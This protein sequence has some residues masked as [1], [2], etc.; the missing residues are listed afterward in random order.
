MWTTLGLASAG[1]VVCATLFKPEKK[2]AFSDIAITG[3]NAKIKNFNDRICK[4][5]NDNNVGKIP[6][7]PVT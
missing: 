1:V 5:A 4:F 6:V 2:N 7:V 3:S